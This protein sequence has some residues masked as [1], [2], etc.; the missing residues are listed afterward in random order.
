V[1]VSA[2]ANAK[3]DYLG[4]VRGRA[5]YLVMPPLLTYLTGGLAYGGASSNTTL[6][7]SVDGPCGCGNFP[8]V[9]GST[10]G[11]RLGCELRVL[12]GR[13][14]FDTSYFARR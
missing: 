9:H 12:D 1:A 3:V 10:S 11:P 7:E 5:G 6:A 4:T 8:S 14:G 2:S 13:D